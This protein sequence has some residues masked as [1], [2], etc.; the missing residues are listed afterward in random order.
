MSK[1]VRLKKGLDISLLGE[2]E[3]IKVDLDAP[4]TVALKPADFHGLVPK[5]VVKEGGKVKVGS[6]VFYDKYNEDVKYV[7]PVSGE[8]TEIVRGAKRRILEVIIKPDGTNEA[9]KVD[10]VDPSSLEGEKVKEMMLAHGLW[11]FLVQRPLDIVADP[12]VK[13]KAIF[14]STFDSAPLAPDFDFIIHDQDQYFQHG[15][16][17]LAKLTDGKVHLTL[18]GKV[19]ADAAFQ[20]AKNVQI[21]KISGKH[22]AGNVGTQIHHIDPINKGET[23]FTVK[24]QDVVAI[25]KFFANGQFDPMRTIAYTGSEAKSRKYYRTI[26]GANLTGLISNNLET[27]NVRVI[28][29]NP[30]TGTNVG[31]DGY[32]GFYDSQVTILP[33]GDHYKFLLTKGWL[34]PGF[35]KFSSH[36]LFPTWI[37][38]N[39]KYRLDTNLN[40]E[41]RGFVVT[42]EMEKVL[43]FDILPMQLIKAI[44][45]NDIDGMEQ[46]GIYEIAPEDFALCEYVCTSKISIQEKVREGLDVIKEECM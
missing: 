38:K 27:E 4:S 8:I 11:P 1:T 2:A 21:N 45:T 12:N 44:M 31:K 6:V 28:S 37:F 42:G 3:K 5:M 29:G 35:D 41:E 18:N 39:K 16:N 14:I 15:L 17:A 43:P 9:V 26:I 22:P 24:P 33:E 10:P 7:S 30:L 25:G 46:L 23:V 34:G 19:P 13:P 32:L 36:R 20:N 40:G